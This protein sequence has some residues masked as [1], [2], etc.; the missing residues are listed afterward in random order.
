MPREIDL[1]RSAGSPNL[2]SLQKLNLATRQ[3]R[4]S[5]KGELWKLLVPKFLNRTEKP[6]CARA[7]VLRITIAVL[8]LFHYTMVVVQRVD[9][10]EY[11]CNILYVRIFAKV[12]LGD[13]G[14]DARSFF[15]NVKEGVL[16]REEVV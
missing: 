14:P 10:V 1:R 6:L 5:S 7:V 16:G 2:L 9:G 11:V 15:T 3:Q 13:V 4:A 12:G 8:D